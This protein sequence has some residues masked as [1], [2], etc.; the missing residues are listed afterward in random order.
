MAR[1]ASIPHPSISLAVQ[2]WHVRRCFPQ[3]K[4]R[5]DKGCWVGSLQPT[6]YSPVYQVRIDYR[7]HT[8]PKAWVLSPS[9]RMNAKHLHADRSLC[10]YWPPD[11]SWT[12]QTLI[13]ETII[14]WTAEWLIFY[15]HWQIT[16]QWI[17]PEAPHRPKLAEPA[18]VKRQNI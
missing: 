14:P 10:L 13:A 2:D 1:K 16:D 7:L 6:E 8:V 11:N 15:E 3:F 4:Y 9:I 18:K 12:P 17:G 5:R